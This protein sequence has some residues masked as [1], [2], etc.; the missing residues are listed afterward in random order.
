M[1]LRLMN[2]LDVEG[3]LGVIKNF[4]SDQASEEQILGRIWT[5]IEILDNSYGSQR[6][7]KDMGGFV[8]F[9]SGEK[10]KNRILDFYR[11]EEKSAEYSDIIC[12][13][14]SGTWY[15]DL[16]LRSSDDAVIIVYPIK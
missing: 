10:E 5:A 12:Q 15:E 4:I 14:S 13:T 9:T 3:S 11:L 8:F 6:T 16:Y 2:K 7:S 1:H